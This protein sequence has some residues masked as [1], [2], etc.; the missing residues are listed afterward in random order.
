MESS[1]CGRCSSV[2]TRA[3]STSCLPSTLTATCRNSPDATTSANWIRSSNWVP[4]VTAWQGR[5]CGIGNSSLIMACHREHVAIQQARRDGCRPPVLS[6]EQGGTAA[7]PSRGR[8]LQGS[9]QGARRARRGSLRQVTEARR[10]AAAA[11]CSGIAE[12][13]LW[14]TQNPSVYEPQLRTTVGSRH[15]KRSRHARRVGARHPH[16]LRQN[17]LLLCQRPRYYNLEWKI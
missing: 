13:T 10:L 9:D 7:R 1:R 4:S 16:K 2:P 14:L 11:S 12:S 3:R 5:G 15:R 8:N 6:A 17:R